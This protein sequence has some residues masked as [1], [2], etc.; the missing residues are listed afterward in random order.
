[1][2]SDGNNRQIASLD[3]ICTH[4]QGMS[5]ILYCVYSL[6]LA[7]L[8]LDVDIRRRRAVSIYLFLIRACTPSI[9]W[10]PFRVVCSLTTQ[11]GDTAFCM[12]S[13]YLSC[14]LL[15]KINVR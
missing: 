15:F 7:Y 12:H 2:T 11:T 6:C 14:L 9:S 4:I 5:R 3:F 13:V 8:V 1:V 10:Q